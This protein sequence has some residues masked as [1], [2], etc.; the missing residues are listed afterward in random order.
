M[1]TVPKYMTAV[2]VKDK[3]GREGGGRRGRGK[4]RTVRG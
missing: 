4:G 2:V 1:K 3:V